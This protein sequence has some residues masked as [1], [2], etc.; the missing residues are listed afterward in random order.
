MIENQ[1]SNETKDLKEIISNRF[2]NQV[3]FSGEK[4]N[5]LQTKIGLFS[6]KI[7]LIGILFGYVWYFIQPIF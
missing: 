5:S 7:I 2:Q 3:Q 6:T 1:I 4:I